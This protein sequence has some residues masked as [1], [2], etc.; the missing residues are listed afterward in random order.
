MVD[1]MAEQVRG[2][3]GAPLYLPLVLAAVGVLA[4]GA[5]VSSGAVRRRL[6]DAGHAFA[7]GFLAAV[8]AVLAVLSVE[9]YV[10]TDYFRYGSHL[11]AYEFFHYYLG[12]KYAE[13]LGYTRLYAA[14]L[15]ADDETG[16]KWD[17]PSKMIRNL[18]T[19][20]YVA[21]DRCSGVP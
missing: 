10:K 20:G 19:G 11:N 8:L 4:A 21:A 14:A 9:N 7:T 3:F 17:H 6:G 12:S 1:W 13:E 15:I 5:A 16:R 2:A 18:E